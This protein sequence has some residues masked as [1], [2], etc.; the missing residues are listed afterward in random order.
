LRCGERRE[1]NVREWDSRRIAGNWTAEGATAEIVGLFDE[2]AITYYVQHGGAIDRRRCDPE[3]QT[4]RGL[5]AKC[6][7]LGNI[8]PALYV[9]GGARF[10]FL[11]SARNIYLEAPFG[12]SG[13]YPR[14]A[15][16][17]PPAMFIWGSHDRLVPP[18]FG[19]H[20][21]RWLPAARQITIPCCGHVPQVECP[22][23]TDR[24]LLEFFAD[25]ELSGAQGQ[26]R[27]A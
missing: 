21:S 5:V 26:R 15:Q 2:F 12:G 14:L 19:R 7:L 9:A 17:K 13:F 16:L 24:A 6:F 20:V 25:V 4:A 18:A 27:A 10:A 23:E 11:A 8:E 22:E 3:A 1:I